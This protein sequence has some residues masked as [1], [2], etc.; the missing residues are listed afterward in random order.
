MSKEKKIIVFFLY[1]KPGGMHEAEQGGPKGTSLVGGWRE[2][3]FYL[4][5][6]KSGDTFWPIII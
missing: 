5:K 2:H 1:N 6:E 4:D 3:Y